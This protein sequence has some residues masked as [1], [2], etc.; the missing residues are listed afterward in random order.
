MVIQVGFISDNSKS[1]IRKIILN[2]DDMIRKDPFFYRCDGGL[3]FE[4][5]K[6]IESRIKV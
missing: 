1:I 6:E 3:R 5:I 2:S 4:H